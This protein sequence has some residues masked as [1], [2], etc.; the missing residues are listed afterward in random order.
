MEFLALHFGLLLVATNVLTNIEVKRDFLMAIN[1]LNWGV[2]SISRFGSLVM[3]ILDFGN[4]FYCS[5][6][7]VSRKAN[8]CAYNLVRYDFEYGDYSLW[9]IILPYLCYNLDIKLSSLIK[10]SHFIEKTLHFTGEKKLVESFSL[11][12]SLSLENP[13]FTMEGFENLHLGENNQLCVGVED[14]QDQD[15]H[16]ELCLVGRFLAE[17]RIKFQIMKGTMVG[18]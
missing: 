7:H 12:L 17:R 4:L 6:S 5:F 16:L 13:C 14:V 18:V 8:D 9:V 1:E 11:S 3:N 10:C 15:A 2:D